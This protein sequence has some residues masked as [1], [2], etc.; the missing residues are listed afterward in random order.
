MR[1]RVALIILSWNDRPAVLACL[2][3][4]RGQIAGGDRIV[5]VDN[6]SS[7]GSAAAIAATHPQVHLIRNDAN[8]GFAGGN[9][10]GMRWALA[11][12][13]P[14]IMLLNSDTQMPAG[15]LEELLAHGEQHPKLAAIQP[16]LVQQDSPERIDSMGHGLGL[17]PGVRDLGMGQ[18][19]SKAPEQPT[20]I[21]GACA[22]AVLLRSEAL[23]LSGLFDNNLFVLLED[24][25]LMFRLRLAG[26]EAQLLP[27]LRVLHQRGISK[28]RSGELA[29]RRRF[30]LQ[31][32]LVALAFRYWP[33]AA[34]LCSAVGISQAC[35]Q[36]TRNQAGGAGL[37]PALAQVSRGAAQHAST[38]AAA[39]LG[40]V[41]WQGPI[42][43]CGDD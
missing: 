34:L 22:A 32:N 17:L 41:V 35:R 25:E 24:V 15:I 39:Q 27:H 7:D 14:W 36:P 8:L 20:A 38:D 12:R 11:Q 26:F 13:F 43:S 19:L 31:R 30:Y 28:Q 16:L 2:E 37:P 23:R 10:C 40:C 4:L 1:P 42:V 6:A 21:F 9:N 33:N 5:V 3:S 18:A 29:L